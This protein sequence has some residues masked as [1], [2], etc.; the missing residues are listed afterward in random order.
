MVCICLWHRCGYKSPIWVI[1]NGLSF[2][3]FFFWRF[4]L[5]HCGSASSFPSSPTSCLQFSHLGLQKGGSMQRVESE[6]PFRWLSRRAFSLPPSSL[7]ISP[8]PQSR[9]AWVQSSGRPGECPSLPSIQKYSEQE[10]SKPSLCPLLLLLTH[11]DSGQG[12]APSKKCLLSCRGPLGS[13][14]SPRRG[15]PALSLF[16]FH[17]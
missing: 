8:A 5:I 17:V 7:S 15:H 3:K 9:Q 16:G 6:G 13:V 14:G 2:E 12:D 10:R 1:S 11:Q 4:L